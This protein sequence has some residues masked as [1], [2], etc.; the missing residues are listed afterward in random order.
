M[1]IYARQ[2]NFYEILKNKEKRKEFSL[3][4]TT[5]II[6]IYIYFFDIL[7]LDIITLYIKCQ[8]I[9]NNRKVDDE[10]LF[11]L[12]SRFEQCVFYHGDDDYLCDDLM[13]TYDDAAA[14]WFCKCKC[15]NR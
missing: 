9:F 7:I 10:I 11:I 8:S 12:R 14:A 2:V 15:Y 4:T 1:S 6:Y 13:K 5:N 3:L